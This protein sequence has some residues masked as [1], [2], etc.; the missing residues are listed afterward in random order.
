MCTA[1]G[2]CSA[3]NRGGGNKRKGKLKEDENHRNKGW[4]FSLTSLFKARC[5]RLPAHLPSVWTL[6]V[7]AV[8]SVVMVK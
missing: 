5:R 4:H 1:I 2:W 7:E 8:M 6:I 3:N